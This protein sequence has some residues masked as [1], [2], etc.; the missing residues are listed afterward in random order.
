MWET[1][2]NSYLHFFL[3]NFSGLKHEEGLRH[4]QNFEGF[5]EACQ[6]CWLC[7][8]GACPLLQVIEN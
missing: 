3:D 5:T 4:V 1:H 6:K 7:G 2:Q 8:T